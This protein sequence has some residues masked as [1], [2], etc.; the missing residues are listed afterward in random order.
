MNNKT[1]IFVGLCLLA[2]ITATQA[3]NP[4]CNPVNH[5]NSMK[6]VQSIRKY[7]SLVNTTDE[8][9]FEERKSALNIGGQA[10]IKGI[11]FKAFANWDDFSSRSSQILSTYNYQVSI[12]QDTA[13][14]QTFLSPEGMLESIGRPETEKNCGQCLACFT[15]EYP[16]EIYADTV[17]PHE[18]EIVR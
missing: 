14:T 2:T 18:K 17:L 10:L 5:K 3:Q 7:L 12:E 13:Y 1:V 4:P 16:T 15:G 6:F 9:N 11:P 8:S